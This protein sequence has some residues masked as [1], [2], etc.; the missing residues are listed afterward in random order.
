MA[1]RVNG[2][3]VAELQR[4]V[5][6]LEAEN[7]QLRERLRRPP[8]AVP[9]TPEQMLLVA[10]SMPGLVGYVGPDERYWFNNKAFA[11][12]LGRPRAALLGQ[13]VVEVLGSDAHLRLRPYIDAA[14]GG[15]AGTVECELTING[16]ARFVQTSFVPYISSEAVPQGFFQIT[17]DLTEARRAG[18]L[19]RDSERR[20]QDILDAAPIVIFMKD[21]DGRHLFVNRAF[22]ELTGRPRGEVVGRRDDELYAPEA[23]ARFAESDA[24][25]M[26]T[27][28]SVTFEETESFADGPRTHRM[29]KVAMRDADGRIHGVCGIAADVTEQ[30]RHALHQRLLV[31]ELNHRVKNTLAIVQSLAQQSLKAA[32]VEPRKAFERRLSTLAAAHGLLTRESWTGASLISVIE[33]ALAPFADGAAT[34]FET[35]GPELRLT[36]KTAVAIAM[37]LHELATNAAKYGALSRPEGRVAIEWRIA[38]VDGEP[39]LH[40]EWRER[41]GPAVTPPAQRG[42][43]SRMVEKGLAAELSGEVELRYEP[44]GVVCTIN[45]PLPND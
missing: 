13:P 8:S 25:V 34:R 38:D 21:R 14:L 35:R 28:E 40:F 1:S 5:A 22:E 20:L 9:V 37:G 16:E 6:Q 39:R 17:V 33:I 31:D 29:T 44:A 26:A 23:A 2:D 19:M 42:F 41:G 18:T 12:W 10:D 43:G 36:T 45:A 32:D 11:R 27:G 7:E 3:T 24:Q 15:E 30:K 4:R